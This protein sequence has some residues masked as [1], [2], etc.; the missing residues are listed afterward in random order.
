MKK[1]Y[2]FISALGLSAFLLS[3]TWKNNSQLETY[4]KNSH[5]NEA[6]APAGRTGAPGEQNCTACHSGSVQADNGFNSVTIEDGNGVVTDY[7]PG[8]TYTV[9]V[10]MNTINVKNGFE[11]TAFSPSNTMA[12]TFTVT[13]ATNTKLLTGAN[14]K[15]YITHKTAGTALTSWSFAWTAPATNV[16]TVTFYLATNETNANGGSGGDVIRLTQFPIGSTASVNKNS[17]KYEVNVGFNPATNGLQVVMES[18][19]TGEA[20]I[21]IVDLNG[22]SVQFE[23]LGDVAKGKNGY[24][25]MLKNNLPAGTYIANIAVN[26]N[27]ITKKF[28]IQ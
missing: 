20:S 16:G 22:K 6:G 28:V 8:A 9:T 21:N 26:N 11:I 1:N 17:D 13:D 15:K 2:F 4:Y 5:K 19:I 14:S 24:S 12:G 3:F 27:F 25:I 10:T 7:T 23:K 18:T